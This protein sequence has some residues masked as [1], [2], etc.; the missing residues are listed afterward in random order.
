MQTK[1]H[2]HV[3]Q[4]WYKEHSQTMR[5]QDKPLFTVRTHA[6]LKA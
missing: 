6:A 3:H 5:A 4:N 1:T 2:V